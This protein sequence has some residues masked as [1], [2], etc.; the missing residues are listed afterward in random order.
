GGE[1][2][3]RYAG[4]RAGAPAFPGPDPHPG[5]PLRSRWLSCPSD[6]LEVNLIDHRGPFGDVGFD[7]L[8]EV[9]RAARTRLVAECVQPLDRRR[10]RE[11][12]P[13]L[14]VEPADDRFG[15]ARR[16]RKST[17]LNSSH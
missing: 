17:R 3:W 5:A 1:G 6:L 11:D 7:A 13:D 2:R 10:L 4:D 12:A 9:V 14:A 16:D 15:K 8:P